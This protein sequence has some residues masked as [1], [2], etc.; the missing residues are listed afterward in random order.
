MQTIIVACVEA[1]Q[2]AFKKVVFFLTPFIK[3][4]FMLYVYCID[5]GDRKRGQQDNICWV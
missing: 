1:E 2:Y 4:E 5:Y 3:L